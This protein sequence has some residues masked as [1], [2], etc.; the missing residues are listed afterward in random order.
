MSPETLGDG[1]RGLGWQHLVN[2]FVNPFLVKQNL[3]LFLMFLLSKW[4]IV[5]LPI[6]NR[7]LT[8]GRAVSREILVVCYDNFMSDV[9]IG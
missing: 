8:T 9:Q 7:N 4:Y 6:N 3:N 2:H 5:F 1:G